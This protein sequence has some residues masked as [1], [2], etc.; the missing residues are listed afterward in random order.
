MIKVVLLVIIAA[1]LIGCVA[2]YVA[3]HSCPYPDWTAAIFG[4]IP[5]SCYGGYTI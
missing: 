3:P 1:L 2:T 4:A 5:D